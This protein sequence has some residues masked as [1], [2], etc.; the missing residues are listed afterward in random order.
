MTDL[1]KEP[2]LIY[3]D[4]HGYDLADIDDTCKKML[5]TAQ[6]AGNGV[7]LIAAVLEMAQVG[8]QHTVSQAK[9]LLPEP[10]EFPS[11]SSSSD[12]QP[13]PQH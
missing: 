2:Q 8:I 4:S 10:V 11:D 13:V 3:I 7:A 1:S 5:G 6:T 9:K 12:D